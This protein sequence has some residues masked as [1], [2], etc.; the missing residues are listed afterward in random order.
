MKF[1]GKER[2][3]NEKI[4]ENNLQLHA[5][6]G[7]VFDTWILLNNLPC[8]KHIVD[9]IKHGK[10]IV[11]LRVFKGY[12]QYKKIPQYLVFRCGLTHSNFS[13]K[14]LG[15]TFKIR[16]EFLKTEMNH[17]EVCSD[18]WKDK[19]S[20]WLDYLGN[21]VFCTASSDARYAKA[22]EEITGCGMKDCL[23]LPSLGW[24]H[25]KSLKTEG[26]EPIYT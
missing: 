18:T 8:D 14:N 23:S 12:I 24:K 25:V 6:N 1:K 3:F 7:S 16:K 20:E 9:I 21:D 11:S 15:K 17:D 13:F 26:D 19:K 5:H 22:M 10:G 4:V 2:K